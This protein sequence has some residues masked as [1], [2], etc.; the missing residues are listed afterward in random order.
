M[1]KSELDPKSVEK[2]LKHFQILYYLFPNGSNHSN[3]VC[4][5]ADGLNSYHQV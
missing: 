2:G 4:L 1:W 5:G 3:T